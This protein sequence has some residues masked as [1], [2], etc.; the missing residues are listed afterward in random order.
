[1]PATSR[2]PG[3]TLTLSIG[4]ALGAVGSS[5]ITVNVAA[6]NDQPTLTATANDPTFTEGGQRRR[7]V[8]QRHRLDGRR[9]ARPSPR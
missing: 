4:D 2:R 7:P 3:R 5:A 8:R 1:M 6:V 9:P